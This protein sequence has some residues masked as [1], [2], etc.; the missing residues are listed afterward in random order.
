MIRKLRRQFILIATAAVLII[1]TALIGVTAASVKGVMNLFVSR[2]L[3]SFQNSDDNENFMTRQLLGPLSTYDVFY[4]KITIDADNTVVSYDDSHNPQSLTSSSAQALADKAESSSRNNRFIYNGSYYAWISETSDDGQTLT[5]IDYTMVMNWISQIR[6]IS[7]LVGA[8]GFIFFELLIIIFSDRAIQP[9]LENE[10]NQ[11]RF[12]TNA[13]HELK[14]P[15]AVISADNEVIEALHGRDEWTDSIRSQVKRL[16]QLITT[17]V[18]LAKSGE[19][20]KIELHDVNLSEIVEASV[21][22]FHPLAEKEKLEMKAD[23]EKNVLVKSDEKILQELAGI[24]LDNALK[25]CDEGGCIGI[26]VHK[27]GS[28]ASF[29]VSN[30][31]KDG[32]DQNYDKFF[33]R[34][35]RADTSHNSAKKGFG[36]GLSLARE[37]TESIRA[38]IKAEWKDGRI[39]F[40]VTL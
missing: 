26:D 14:T 18:Q 37:L 23:I 30:D 36:I 40:T 27:N 29:S 34:F 4:Y 11:K 20:G 39:F 10:E 2:A 33:E 19:R 22:D 1:L 24:L 38:K 32:K 3:E 28:H 21:N 15:V 16:N 6:Y 17:M 12:I 31:Y 5:I 13:S 35:Y 25:Y 9:A 8:A 7:F